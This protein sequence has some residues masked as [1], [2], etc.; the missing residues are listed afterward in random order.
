MKLTIIVPVHNEERHLA[1]AVERLMSS[2][3]PGVAREW[4]FVDDRSSDRS[5]EILEKLEPVYGFRLIRSLVNSGK[6]AAVASALEHVTGDYVMIHDADLEYDPDEI[7]LLLEPLLDGRA[8]VV[9]GSRFSDGRH[10][11]ATPSYLANRV[12]T[13]LS[14]LT[15]GLKLT[16][17]ETC[18]KVFPADL[19]KAMILRSRRFG[20]EIELTAYVAMLGVHVVE[21][22][23]SYA[24][25]TREQGKKVGWRDGVAALGHLIRFNFL[26]SP[27]QAYRDLPQK[28]AK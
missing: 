27:E 4:I 2:K 11:A 16:D 18:Y 26:T 13:S 3:C 21:V 12:L 14:N 5:L 23:I 20:I 10:R 17:M 8:E 19:L 1:T 25:R 6:G 9:Y 22:P 24:P 15:T 7:P 28:Y